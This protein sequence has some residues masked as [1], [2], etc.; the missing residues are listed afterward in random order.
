MLVSPLANT[1]YT[2]TASDRTCRG[3]N[4]VQVNSLIT[5]TVS[6]PIAAAFICEGQT[7]TIQASSSDANS[8]FSWMPVGGNTS[9]A[10]LTPSSTNAYTVMNTN[11][12]GC[13][14]N[15]QVVIVVTPQPSITI[16]AST[17]LVCTG[18]TVSLIASGAGT[19]TWNNGPAG[20][21]ATVTPL[22][23]A[24]I[25]SVTATAAT[26]S[27]TATKSIAI[28]IYEPIVNS[29]STAS[30]CMGQS[31]TL[32][33]S[34]AN[35]YSWN[36]VSSGTLGNLIITP[37]ITSIYTLTTLSNSLNTAC[38]AVKMTTISVLALPSVSVVANKSVTCRYSPVTLTA[39]GALTYSW[40]PL[41]LTSSQ[42]TFAPLQTITYTVIGTDANGCQNTATATI[43]VVI[44]DNNT[45]VDFSIFETTRIFPNPA[46]DH[47]SIF[48]ETVLQAELVDL[49]GRSRRQMEVP[50]GTTLLMTDDLSPGIY[51][52]ILKKDAQ[53]EVRKVLIG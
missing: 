26:N 13:S 46:K 16:V 28:V 37:S 31:L 12:L 42:F 22:S 49:N 34:G 53:R 35:T 36:G 9:I 5:P 52:L 7:Y 32:S 51:F 8:T 18:N 6:L 44:C 4:T 15:A 41:N 10:A 29:P 40:L 23:P 25:Y 3:S 2:V 19:Y 14:G 1:L 24:A 39:I 30:I 38:T 11:S 48:S 27:C 21:S 47:L 45:S 17:T 20:A 43:R 33:A 50:V